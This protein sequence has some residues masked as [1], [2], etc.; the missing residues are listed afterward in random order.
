VTEICLTS[1]F[2]TSVGLTVCVCVCVCLGELP[3]KRFEVVPAILLEQCISGP[4]FVFEN[5]RTDA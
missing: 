2:Q 3:A 5:A 4:A 1:A